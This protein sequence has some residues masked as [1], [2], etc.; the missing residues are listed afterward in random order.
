M[1]IAEVSWV[2]I[3]FTSGFCFSDQIGLKVKQEVKALTSVC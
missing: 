3:Y 2:I 1:K